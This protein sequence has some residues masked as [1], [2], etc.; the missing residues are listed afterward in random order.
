MYPVFPLNPVTLSLANLV[1]QLK[2]DE[3]IVCIE[4]ELPLIEN[5]DVVTRSLFLL[6]QYKENTL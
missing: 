6:L 3:F 5:H 4:A 2:P 1:I